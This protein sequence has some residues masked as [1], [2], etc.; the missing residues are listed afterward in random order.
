MARRPNLYRAV[1]PPTQISGAE[2]PGA[3]QTTPKVVD[4]SAIIPSNA[5]AVEIL[6]VLTGSTKAYYTMRR[7]GGSFTAT[8]GATD[9]AIHNSNDYRTRKTH[10]VTVTGQAIQ[11]WFSASWTSTVNEAYVTGYWIDG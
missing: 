4:L 8:I 1:N 3:T 6:V 5:I 9:L 10:V 7:N 2:W 11:A